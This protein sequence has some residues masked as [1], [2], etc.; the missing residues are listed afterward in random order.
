MY[1]Y[2]H[3]HTHTYMYMYTTHTHPYKKPISVKAYE[4]RMKDNLQTKRKYSQR[5]TNV[6]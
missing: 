3:V 2:T 6:K 4:K 1:I 5:Y